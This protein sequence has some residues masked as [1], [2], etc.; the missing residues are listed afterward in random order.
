MRPEKIAV[1][2]NIFPQNMV[3]EVGLELSSILFFRGH[4]LVYELTVP[5]AVP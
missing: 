3:F 1:S 4:L 2:V 5:W